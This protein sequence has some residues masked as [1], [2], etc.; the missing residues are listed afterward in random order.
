MPYRHPF[1]MAALWAFALPLFAQTALPPMMALP[2]TDGDPARIDFA[3]LPVLK[4]EH[5]VVS[6]G[7]AAWPFR[8]HNYLAYY[9]GQ[10]WCMWSHGKKIEDYPRQKVC[11][12][13]SADGIR[14]SAPNDVAGSSEKEGFRR[15]ARGFWQ[16]DG[17][18]LALAGHDE[19]LNEKGKV[20]FFGKSLELQSFA[21][22]KHSQTWRP[23]GS[24]YTDA[25]NNFP[26]QKNPDGQ[27]VMMC[28]D[29]AMNSFSLQGGVASLADWKKTPIAERVNVVNGQRFRPEEPICWTLPD[30]RLLALFRDNAKSRRIYRAVSADSGAHWTSPERTNFPDATSKFIGLRTSRGYYVLVSSANPAGRN[31]LCLSTSDDGVTFT[32]MARLPI[33]DSTQAPDPSLSPA[34]QLSG[35]Q[36]PD[37]IEHDGSLL[38][39]Y[40]RGK[41]VIETVKIPLDAIDALRRAPQAGVLPADAPTPAVKPAQPTAAP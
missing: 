38:I 15:I 18:F 10:Y 34:R 33:P 12:A 20:V 28:R 6:A 23:Q 3:A 40:S 2:G 39:A 16:R 41:T 27:W 5:A 17:Q 21:W 8:L 14:W 32:R 24:V 1:L 9:D 25:I 7:D 30:N 4:G 13:T 26:P 31:P 37:V 36:Y 29:H 35:Y 19:A 11:Y 22:D